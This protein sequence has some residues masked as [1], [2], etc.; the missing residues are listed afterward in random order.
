MGLG[1]LGQVV[2]VEVVGFGLLCIQ[3]E[4]DGCWIIWFV[5]YFCVCIERAKGYF[6]LQYQNLTLLYCL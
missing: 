1:C 5:G 2:L 4:D 6:L 3:V